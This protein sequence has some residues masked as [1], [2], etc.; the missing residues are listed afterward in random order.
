MRVGHLAEFASQYVRLARESERR[1]VAA[2]TEPQAMTRSA[3]EKFNR[4]L[5]RMDSVLDEHARQHE[6]RLAEAE[7]VRE[8]ER[9]QRQR[10]NFE[11]RREIAARYD[12]AFASFGVAAPEAADDEGPGRYRARLFNRLARK[13]PQGHDLAQIRADDLGSQPIVLD[14]FE[15]MLLEAAKAEGLAPSEGNLP[16]NGDLVERAR[17][18][19][20]TGT[21]HLDFYG[22]E[23]FIK[24]LSQGGRRVLRVLDPKTQNVLMGPPF[25]SA[26]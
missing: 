8:A 9:I 19:S 3:Q 14:N 20:A 26:R 18:D 13:L 4:T 24:G 12:A 25:H 22:K 17:V 21:K 16:A 6:A 23:P 5:A 1:D 11:Q 10:D 2:I 15:R 7:A